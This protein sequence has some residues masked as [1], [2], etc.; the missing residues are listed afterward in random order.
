MLVPQGKIAMGK[1]ARPSCTARK[2][3]QVEGNFDDC[4]EL[5]RKLTADLPDVALVN[6]VNPY[7]I[8]GQKTA[9]FEIFDALG[10]RPTCTPCRSATRATSPRTGTATPSTRDGH[11]H[12]LPR[13]LGFQAAGAAPLVHGEP[14]KRP[15]DHRHRDPHRRPRLVG[16]RRSRPSDESDG[17]FRAATDDEILAAYRLLARTEGVFVEPA[18]AA[19]VAGLLSRRGRLGARGSHR[20]LHGHR[21]TA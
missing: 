14:V 6:S 2:L 1:L 8:E 19:S 4:L 3:I 7:R 11:R 5:A 15:G 9:A 10:T 21:A 18:S 13:M 20:G 17:A 16:R 12:R